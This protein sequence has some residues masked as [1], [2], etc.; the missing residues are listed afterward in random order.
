MVRVSTLVP[1]DAF[2]LTVELTFKNPNDV[3]EFEKAFRPLAEYCKLHEP[4]TL[5]Y[6]MARSETEPLKVRAMCSIS[7]LLDG[8]DLHATCMACLQVVIWERYRSKS[9]YLDVHKSSKPFQDFRPKL[10]ALGPDI[11]GHGWLESDIGYV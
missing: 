9:D 8:A 4:G 1:S 5:S 3:N 6:Q 11:K 10:S 2:W 7:E